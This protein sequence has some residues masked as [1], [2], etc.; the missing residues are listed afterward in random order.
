[1]PGIPLPSAFGQLNLPSGGFS[2]G[3]DI[4][5]D[6]PK[7]KDFL[8]F[9]KPNSFGSKS[10]LSVSSDGSVAS[11]PGNRA[12][13]RAGQQPAGM[14]SRG[15][16]NNQ[17]PGSLPTSHSASPV[18]LP[19]PSASHPSSPLTVIQ[20]QHQPHIPQPLNPGSASRGSGFPGFG[21][22]AMPSV[23]P[24]PGAAS[25]VGFHSGFSEQRMVDNVPRRSDAFPS[26]PFGA[27][28]VL[29]PTAPP[30]APGSSTQFA[31]NSHRINANVVPFTGAHP[32]GPV[33]Q[34]TRPPP[35]PHGVSRQ[36]HVP[37]SYV[38][39]S[40]NP[41]FST[42]SGVP[43]PALPSGQAHLNYSTSTTQPVS[44]P[45]LPGSKGGMTT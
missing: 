26:L 44:G 28:S 30:G 2:S 14:D 9:M 7:L 34:F 3:A 15:L 10:A 40:Y 16:L 19:H 35:P 22:G 5:S 38:E 18:H 41:K 37:G 27:P 43:V 21:D 13:L 45:M 42:E 24:E 29:S 6:A 32:G 12:A 23:A 11:A 8:P 25:G 4:P 36:Y 20:G 39:T 1:M 17:Q 33:E 31:E